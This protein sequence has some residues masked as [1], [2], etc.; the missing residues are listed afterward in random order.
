MCNVILIDDDKNQLFLNSILLSEK[1]S[2]DNIETFHNPFKALHYIKEK[3]EPST[4]LIVVD[5]NMPKMSAW[6]FLNKINS[7]ISINKKNQMKLFLTSF[8]ENPRDIDKANNHELV[9]GFVDKEY[10][11]SEITNYAIEIYGKPV[12]RKSA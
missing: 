7:D 2:I 5:I 12:I 11:A 8:S 3:F 10:L 1:D 4:D 9:I 6:Q